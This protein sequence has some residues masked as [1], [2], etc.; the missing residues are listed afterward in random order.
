MKLTKSR[1]QKILNNTNKQTRKK[2]KHK[3]KLLSHN[4]TARYKKPF[5]LLNIS[6]KNR[7]LPFWF[8]TF[9]KTDKR[10]KF[11]YY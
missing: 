2:Y 4:N 11:M 6:L 7:Y 1:L 5:N 9:T 8:Y 3:S 10:V